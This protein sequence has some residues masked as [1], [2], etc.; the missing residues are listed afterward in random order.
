LK[1]FSL[2]NCDVNNKIDQYQL[3]DWQVFI[4]ANLYGLYKDETNRLFDSAYLEVAKKNAKSF[5]ASAIS[6]YEAIAD[7]EI[8]AHVVQ[9]ANSV[10]QSRICLDYTK[11]MIQNSPAVV[12]RFRINRNVLYNDAPSG[13]NKI[14]IKAPKANSL[15]GYRCSTII[16]DEFAF[17]KDFS[18][19]QNLL[20]GM[21]QRRNKLE[22]IITTASGNKL[23][24]PAYQ[25]RQTATNVLEGVI[26][27]D[28]MFTVIF[29][30]DDPD[31]ERA[32]GEHWRK[33][34]P[35]LGHSVTLE[36]LTNEYYKATLIPDD[37]LAFNIYHLNL[38]QEQGSNIWLED[39]LIKNLMKDNR[40]IPTGSSVFCTMDLAANS[41]I[42]SMGLL[43]YD[44]DKKEFL[45]KTISILPDGSKNKIRPGSIDLRKWKKTGSNL[46]KQGKED[47]YIIFGQGKVLDENLVMDVLKAIN[48]NYRIVGGVGFDPWNSLILADRIERELG[49]RT[50][51]IPQTIKTLNFPLR[52]LET[53]V[54]QERIHFEQSPV[55][56]WMFSNCNLITDSNGNR[57]VSKKNSEAVDGVITIIGCFHQFFINYGFQ[58]SV[59]DFK[60]IFLS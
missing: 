35:S 49:I 37:L 7:N 48:S 9:I 10:E 23:T 6:I 8:N 51:Q 11:G 60:R 4:L 52:L 16:L 1:F 59:E 5:F 41:D 47:G 13:V 19:R 58:N 3:I 25:I 14:E 17:A 27:N 55:L 12:D 54:L 28:S 46:L 45:A 56:R 2:L 36:Q 34:N 33:S 22:F 20:T 53:A 21:I 38:W 18:V 43:H 32:P 24:S 26:E 57:K 50:N 44:E 40:R 39:E 42:V 15:N 29:T 31:R 30:L